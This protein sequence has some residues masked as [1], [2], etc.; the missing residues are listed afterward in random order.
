MFWYQDL[1]ILK[2]GEFMQKVL[3]WECEFCNK[4]FESQPI[5]ID[6]EPRCPQCLRKKDVIL[7]SDD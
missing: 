6:I 3:K 1:Y 5:G 7:I 4:T 2:N